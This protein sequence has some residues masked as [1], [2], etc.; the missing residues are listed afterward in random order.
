MIQK[1]CENVLVEFWPYKMA[2]LYKKLQKIHG[3]KIEQ[4]YVGR[5]SWFTDKQKCLL[6]T[7]P[8]SSSLD[9]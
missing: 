2:Y 1:T 8:S 4:N 7:A 6:V 3:E 9:K 5:K